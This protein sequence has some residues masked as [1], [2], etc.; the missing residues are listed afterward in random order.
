MGIEIKM[1]NHL[2]IHTDWLYEMTDNKMCWKDVGKLG[3]SNIAGK[4][5]KFC[6][7]FEK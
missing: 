2:P 1:T 3:A 7:H 4:N 5:M 6:S